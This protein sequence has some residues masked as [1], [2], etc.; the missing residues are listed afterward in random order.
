[1]TVSPKALTPLSGAPTDI[2]E[3]LDVFITRAVTDD[4][5]VMMCELID[6]FTLILPACTPDIQKDCEYFKHLSIKTIMF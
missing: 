4:I 1:M 2:R 6:S 5:H 3:Q